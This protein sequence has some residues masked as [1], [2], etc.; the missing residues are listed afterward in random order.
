MSLFGKFLYRKGREH[1]D[2][3]RLL[4]LILK[5]AKFHVIPYLDD[6]CEPHLFVRKP[7]D[8][9]EEMDNLPFGGIRIFFKG[10]ET[11]AFRPQ[12]KPDVQPFGSAYLLDVTGMYR[13]LANEDN[14]NAG[15]KTVYYI[16]NEIKDFFV[17]SAKAQFKQEV[18]DDDRD[19]GVITGSTGTDYSNF[20]NTPVRF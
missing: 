5:R 20:I 9:G 13:S 3:L 14:K 2:R 4:G 1:Q 19:L 16:I 8:F 12:M 10:S 17:Q 15:I 18:P 11:L 7:K 6:H